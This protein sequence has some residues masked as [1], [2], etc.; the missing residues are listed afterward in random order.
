MN[1]NT[2][3]F[4]TIFNELLQSKE[5]S[6]AP[7]MKTECCKTAIKEQ[8]ISSD[9]KISIKQTRVVDRSVEVLDENLQQRRNIKQNS[10]QLYQAI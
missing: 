7:L 8:L 9:T 6:R 2:W 5:T 1:T 4:D 3:D 10:S